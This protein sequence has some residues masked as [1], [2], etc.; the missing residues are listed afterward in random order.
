MTKETLEQISTRNY[1]KELDKA[2]ETCWTRKIVIAAITYLSAI[3]FLWMIDAPDPY[4][5]AL[6]PVGGFLLS[7]STLSPI[8]KW[9]VSYQNQN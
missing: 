7:T 4:F 9:W 6:V 5:S 8:K 2:W 1:A 3:I